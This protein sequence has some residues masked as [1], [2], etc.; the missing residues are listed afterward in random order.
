MII[1]NN[2][3][4]QWTAIPLALIMD[5]SISYA[6]RGVYM[7]IAAL[8]EQVEV[9]AK[10]LQGE[11][12]KRTIAALFLELRNSGWIT[13]THE[14][15]NGVKTYRLNANKAVAGAEKAS[16]WVQN[17]LPSECKKCTQRVQKMHPKG[18]KNAPSSPDNKNI[19]NIYNNNIYNN[20]E[21]ENKE[22]LPPNFYHYPFDERLTIEEKRKLVIE[23]L[24]KYVKS[25]AIE[26]DEA[27]R[28]ILYWT[29]PMMY[30][31]NAMRMEDP[32]LKSWNLETR[33]RLWNERKGKAR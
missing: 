33:I 11:L 30:L 13:V 9:T 15:G 23:E 31:P 10:M 5:D 19:Y 25:G 4:G 27:R 32:E 17:M 26:A 12:N 24:D 28:F 3:V 7:R 16:E 2:I 18:A 8:P 14:S 1:I 20:R 6:A 22:T 21:R 29:E